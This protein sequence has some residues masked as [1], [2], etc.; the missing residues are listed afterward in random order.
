MGWHRISQ[1]SEAHVLLMGWWWWWRRGGGQDVPEFRGTSTPIR[2]HTYSNKYSS[3]VLG[4]HKAYQN[5]GDLGLK[6]G[7]QGEGAQYL[8]EL[9]GTS[10][11][12]RGHITS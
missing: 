5:L 9:R 11:S 2:G 6:L 10:H 12:L 1:N 8:E 4:R 3:C 7:K